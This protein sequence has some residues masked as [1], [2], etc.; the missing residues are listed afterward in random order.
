MTQGLFVPADDAC[1]QAEAES[2]RD[3]VAP[4]L[5]VAA[6]DQERDDVARQSLGDDG[7]AAAVDHPQAGVS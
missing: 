7:P 6:F 3:V 4:G 1:L 2:S 5:H